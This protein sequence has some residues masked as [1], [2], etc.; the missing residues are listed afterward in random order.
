MTWWQGDNLTGVGDEACNHLAGSS[1]TDVLSVKILF[2]TQ[3]AG[4]K[5]FRPHRQNSP[6]MSSLSTSLSHY[7]LVL[8]ESFHQPDSS[9]NIGRW[10]SLLVTRLIKGP[11]ANW[12]IPCSQASL[13]IE[14]PVSGLG[15]CSFDLSF[16][17]CS[18]CY[19]WK[20]EN[21]ARIAHAVQ[22]TPD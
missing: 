20:W 2:F 10:V 19:R 6:A 12:H 9:F 5:Q 11:F 1:K 18:L 3:I 17:L 7:F 15:V 4:L 14:R 16:T 8:K 13:S 21:I 22:V